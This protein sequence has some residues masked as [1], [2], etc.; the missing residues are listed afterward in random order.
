[1]MIHMKLMLAA[2]LLAS[3]YAGSLPVPFNGVYLGIWA[4]PAL[5]SN[6]EAA[7]EMREASIGQPFALHL[8][9][10]AWTDLAG[11][12]DENGILQPDAQLTG[13]IGHGRIP[14]ISWACDDAVA[15][16]DHVIADGNPNEDAIITA[17]A[18]ALAQYSGPVLLR[19]LWEFNDL[20]NHQTCRGDAGGT[21]T[22][23]VYSDFIG[24]WQHIWK[25]FQNAGA[26]NVLFL[27]NPGHYDADGNADDPHAFYPG[28]SYVD[29]IGIDTYQ[30]AT[31]ATFAGDFGL[32]YSNFSTGQYGDKPLMVGENGS[33]GFVQ[34]NVELQK[35]YL[36]GLLSEVQAGRY[37]LLKAY[38]YFDAGG[39][40]GSWVLDDNNGQG[41]GGL[42]A[43]TAVGAS[44]SFSPPAITL[45]ANAEG[46]SPAIAPNT[47]VEI[48]G[49]SLS[50]GNDARNWTNSDFLNNQLPAKLDGSSA[51]VNG[52]T[53]Y[54]YYISPSQINIL[55]PPDAM[56]GPVAVQVTNNGQTAA[57]IAQAQSISP[58]FFVF[59][60]GPYVAATHANGAYI[61][62]TTLFPGQT[63]PAKPGETIVLYANGFGST[64][65]PVVSGSI[66]QSGSLATMP[67]IKIGAVAASVQFAGLVAPGQYQFNVVVPST[68]ADGDQTV[69]ATYGGAV[70]QA[71]TL[72]TIQH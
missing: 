2:A 12:L 31:T 58:S 69:T 27:W 5:A 48:K 65:T 16:S 53:A 57:F 61:G 9:Y 68:L 63:T 20:G 11:E 46:E 55:T 3:A 37:P 19:W 36:Q 70:T 25:L 41:N 33:Q 13:D 4:N 21:P 6:Q 8:H 44:A 26:I 18:K 52:K 28:N 60:G 56:S 62:T 29:W 64:S 59:N 72:I 47:W 67:A 43:F 34:N 1:M 14:V 7:I 66:N 22:P 49:L 51:T 40:N 42:A 50:Q 45:V 35:I 38:D 24:A 54:V 32:F 15:N 17:T 23:Q 39:S 10:Y 30:R 71:G